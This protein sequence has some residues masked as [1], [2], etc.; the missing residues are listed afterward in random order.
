MA[1]WCK[2]R[3]LGQRERVT[4]KLGKLSHG[5]KLPGLPG[6][7]DR[8]FVSPNSAIADLLVTNWGT[9]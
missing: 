9:R 1:A 6:S 8:T 4:S 5:R 3:T 2:L 7:V